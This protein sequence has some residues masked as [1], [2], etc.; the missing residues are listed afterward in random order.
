MVSALAISQRADVVPN[1]NRFF[2]KRGEDPYLKENSTKVG[3][4]E[5]EETARIIKKLFG[6]VFE[7]LGDETGNVDHT[8]LELVV[9]KWLD[10]VSAY[11]DLSQYHEDPNE[12]MQIAYLVYWMARIRPLSSENCLQINELLAL[13]LALTAI[14][15]EPDS[16]PDEFITN[17]VY[18]IYYDG[19]DYA[20]IYSILRAAALVFGKQRPL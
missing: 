14:G 2:K 5:V 12:Y 18:R 1:I 8:R 15:L 7:I 16:V 4:A 3:I 20:G 6:E 13:S 19:V 9:K 11:S 10:D 17:T